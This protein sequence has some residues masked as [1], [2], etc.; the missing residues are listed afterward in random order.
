M[1]GTKINMPW[2][3]PVEKS[4]VHKSDLIWLA[5]IIYEIIHNLFTDT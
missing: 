1:S 2:V 3:F 4:I 5:V